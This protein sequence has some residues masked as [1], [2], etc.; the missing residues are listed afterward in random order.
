MNGLP[1]SPNA[2]RSSLVAEVL[3]R[4]G[5]LRVRVQIRGESMLPTLWP[6]EVVEIENCSLETVRP[7]EIVLALRDNRLVLHR[8]VGACQPAGFRLRG[9]SV[10]SPDPLFPAE[11]LLGR[12]VSSANEGHTIGRAVGPWFGA[13]WARALGVLFCYCGIAR[14]LALHIR[15]WR[16]GPARGAEPR[17]RPVVSLAGETRP[18][19]SLPEQPQ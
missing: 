16:T 13:T 5:H 8:L 11:A 2:L 1:Q 6:G 19:A 3:R 15:N 9:D 14:R 12:L 17:S 10:P 18:A 7:G 4:G